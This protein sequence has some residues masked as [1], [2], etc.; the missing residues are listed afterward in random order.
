MAS[1]MLVEPA[2]RKQLIA[3]L[4]RVAMFSGP[5]PVRT[6]D[7]SSPSSRILDNGDYAACG[8]MPTEPE[9]TTVLPGQGPGLC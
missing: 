1:A 2:S 8:I 5:W 4:R 7:A 6:C 3:R 9:V